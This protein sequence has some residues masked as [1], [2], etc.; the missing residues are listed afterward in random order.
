MCNQTPIGL[1]YICFGFLK[2]CLF[3]LIYVPA[4]SVYIYFIPTFSN[5]SI[6]LNP[7]SIRFRRL[8]CSMTFEKT[9]AV[10][11]LMFEGTI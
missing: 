8:A 7:E 2:Y 1:V 11:L 5:L 6:H 10:Y 4:H 9:T 3:R